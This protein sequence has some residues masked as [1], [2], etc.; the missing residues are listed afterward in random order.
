MNKPIYN[1]KVF[2]LPDSHRS[3]SCIHSKI[4]EDHILKITIHDCNKS[5]QLHNDLSKPVE[6]IEALDKIDSLTV[7][8]TE[9][10]AFVHENYLYG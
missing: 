9:L 3:M 1:E 6:V 8:L 5:I 4:M 10:R 7:Q 2:L